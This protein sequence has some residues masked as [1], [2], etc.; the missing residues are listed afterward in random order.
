MEL[1]KRGCDMKLIIHD[2]SPDQWEAIKEEYGECTVISDHGTIHPCTGCF[3][4]WNKTPGTCVM[5]DGYENMGMLIHHADEVIVISRYTYGGFSG[6]VKNVF[7][8]SLGYVLPHFELVHGESHHQKRYDEEKPYT[9]IFYGHDLSESEKAAAR[10]YARAVTT[11][12]RTWVK[13]VIFRECPED[14]RPEVTKNETPNSR[15]I[16]LNAS[17]RCKDGNSAKLARQLS[18]Q[19]NKENETVSLARYLN[20]TEDLIRLLE[21]D[22]DLVLCM[23]LYVDG[24]PSQLIRLMEQMSKNYHG[25]SKRIYVLANMGLFEPG[26]LVNLFEAVHQ[27]CKAMGFEYCGGLG[28]GAGELVGGFME[29]VPFGKWPLTKIA[30][31]MD[32]LSEAI[33]SGTVIDDIYCGPNHFPRSLYMAIANSGWK[34]MAKQNGIREQDLY[35]R[36]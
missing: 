16:L 31:G 14:P 8:R 17:M 24:L 18:E 13:N 28:I 10:R 29:A 30:E 11:N 27:W 1:K 19:L 35:R 5:H 15:V 21:E 22:S 36:L 7:D 20:Q 6:F 9:F 26:Q 33:K 2:L 32:R 12:M 25:A 34:R 4:C 23:P 3:G